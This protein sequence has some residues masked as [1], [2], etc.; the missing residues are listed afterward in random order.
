M[1]GKLLW[2]SGHVHDGG[3]AQVM[4]INGAPVCNST[5]FYANNG[6]FEHNM[7]NG[8]LNGPPAYGGPNAP[9]Q[10]NYG[11][12]AA[13]GYGPQQAPAAPQGYPPQQGPPGPNLPYNLPAQGNANQPPYNDP[14]RPLQYNYKRQNHGGAFGGDHI[15][16][17]GACTDFGDIKRG[18]MMTTRAYYDMIN[19]KP[20]THKGEEERVMGN[21]R[22]FIGPTD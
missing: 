16:R 11:P 19:H 3:T 20:M 18:D 17:P 14:N 5:Q 10:G 21:M 8:P 15:E 4:F 12:Y 13:P 2:T 9:A 7:H 6:Q 22:V 1:N